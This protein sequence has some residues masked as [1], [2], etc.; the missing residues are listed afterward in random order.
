M[1]TTETPNLNLLIRIEKLLAQS[2]DPSCTVAEREAFQNKA[3][4]LMERHRIDRAAVGGHLAKDDVITTEA[5]GDFNGIYGRVRIEIV[6]AIATANDVKLFWTGYQNTRH[7]K[8]YGFK[9]DIDRVIPLANR[10]L[11]D[12]DLRVKLLEASYSMKDTIRQ[13]RG[14][15]QGYADSISMRMNAARRTAETAAKADGIDVASTALVL[16][17]RKRQVNE[18]LRQSNP[19]LRSAGGINSPGIDGYI[20]GQQAGRNADLTNNNAVATRK[21]LGR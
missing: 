8:A 1:T 12:A 21:A 20:G 4:E 17:D 11:A 3:F 6:D 14:F 16:V 2:E 10:L 9:S 18:A 5:V 15:F 19:R 7:L 13:R